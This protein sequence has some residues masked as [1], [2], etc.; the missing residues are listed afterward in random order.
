M[1]RRSLRP[2]TP[3]LLAELLQSSH[4]LSCVSQRNDL[5]K[6]QRRSIEDQPA[7]RRHFSVELQQC[8]E[9][10]YLT[11][12]MTLGSNQALTPRLTNEVRFNYSRNRVNA[13]FTLDTF[14]GAVPPSN[15]VLFPS[16]ASP[17]DAGVISMPTEARTDSSI[18]QESWET[19]R[20][21]RST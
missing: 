3:S 12:S 11:Q 13:F 1:E 17:Q 5:R 19:T 14:G 21:I 18:G 10:K 6:V 8:R 4:R 15:S 20:S 16:F 2:T 9:I 7:W